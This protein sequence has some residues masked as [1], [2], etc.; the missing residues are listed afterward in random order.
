MCFNV[1]WVFYFKDTNGCIYLKFWGICYQLGHGRLRI[2]QIKYQANTNTFTIGVKVLHNWFNILIA[3]NTNKFLTID[4]NFWSLVPSNTNIG[5]VFHD[6]TLTSMK[7]RI[8][9][10]YCSIVVGRRIMTIKDKAMNFL[11]LSFSFQIVLGKVWHEG[12]E[13]K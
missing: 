11:R 12:H 13:H 4:F 1:G 6:C 10:E 2:F 8:P 3:I 5:L 9:R 7:W